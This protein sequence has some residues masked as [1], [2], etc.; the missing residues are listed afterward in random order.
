M[1]FHK[2]H[3]VLFCAALIAL[4][5]DVSDEALQRRQPLSWNM[6]VNDWRI[7]Q[8]FVLHDRYFLRIYLLFQMAMMIA[9][10]LDSQEVT[11]LKQQLSL[12]DKLYG[13]I[14]SIAGVGSIAGAITAT[15]TTKNFRCKRT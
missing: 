2:R 11:F 8:A 1:H 5:P 12:T 13:V 4:L 7:V 14:V 15:A 3:Y 6:I 10:A 9:F